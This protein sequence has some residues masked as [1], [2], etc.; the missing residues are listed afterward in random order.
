[1][2]KATQQAK[3]KIKKTE[4]SCVIIDSITNSIIAK[5]GPN[6]ELAL[7]EAYKKGL[8]FTTEVKTK[9][10]MSIVTTLYSLLTTAEDVRNF[11]VTLLLLF[12]SG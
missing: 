3:L 1:M 9:S 2:E 10:L 8:C 6:A 11:A 12:M 5:H 7:E 4:N